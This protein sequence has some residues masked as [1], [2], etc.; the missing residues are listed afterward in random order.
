MKVVSGYVRSVPGGTP[1]LNIPVTVYDSLTSI[2][3]P[4]GGIYG[5]STNPVNTDASSG[6]FEWT[7][8]LDPGP[9]YIEAVTG[10]GQKK[11]RSSVEQMSAYGI[12]ISDIVEYFTV[13]SNGVASG[14]G[15]EF[16]ASSSGKTVTLDS[17]AAIVAGR[18][19]ETFTT[20]SLTAA[21]N[22][23]LPERWD[24][25]ILRQHIGGNALGRQE[26][27]LIQGTVDGVL[28]TI[29]DD[30]D[31]VDVLLH[32]VKLVQDGTNVTLVDGREFTSYTIPAN[33]I[34]VDKLTA[35]G[36]VSTSEIAK[37]LRAPLAGVEPSYES[38]AIGD[39]SNVLST[40]PTATNTLSWNGSAWVPTTHDHSAAFSPIG[41]LHDDRYYTESEVDTFLA[42][43]SAT[44]HL[45]D[46]RY[47]TESEVDA[48]ISAGGSHVHDDRYYT[49]T[50]VDALLATKAATSH[51][52]DDR[53]YTE[54][55]SDGLLAGKS[56][57]T[58]THTQNPML[59]NAATKSYG[60]T[61][62]TDTSTTGDTLTSCDITLASGVEYD[63]F[64][65][66]YAAL[67]APSGGSSIILGI[68]IG[69]QATTWGTEIQT[70]SAD[71]AA[72]ATSFRTVTGPS[73]QTVSLKAR[74]TGGS[75]ASATTGHVNVFAVPR[76]VPAS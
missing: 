5:G 35:S 37:V 41:H 48:L 71:K 26:I 74:I 28:A 44:S 52:H 30:P 22:T 32:T 59:M 10:V 14:R 11:V 15:D 12:Y 36:N 42:G 67:N 50:E 47:Y 76:N 25:L 56:D 19:L 2:A 53:Y 54:T 8:E 70:V 13:F 61:G 57:T 49:D 58:H 34:E 65:T 18:W 43:K 38:L 27:K 6:Y 55:E 62:V 7:T 20:R 63:I 39:L 31:Y 1:L 46:D 3:I 68:K 16:T 9:I 72:Q 33:S 66:G 24:A 17:G 75:G 60:F 40:A 29:N 73:T 23:T 69:A 51:V 45:H 4:V 64:A 21:N